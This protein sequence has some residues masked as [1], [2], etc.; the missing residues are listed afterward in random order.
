MLRLVPFPSALRPA[1]ISSGI[2]LTLVVGAVGCS[3][4]DDDGAATTTSVDDTGGSASST[5]SSTTSV[6]D[7]TSSTG[8][9]TTATS[10]DPTAALTAVVYWARPYGGPERIDLPAYTDVDGVEHPYV[11]YGSVSNAGPGDASAP[12]V[13]ATWRGADGEVVATANGRVVDPFGGDLGALG[14]GASADFIV[15][16]DDA[17]V[18]PLLDSIAPELEGVS[19]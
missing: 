15:V 12:V 10:G 2:V 5:T 7:T 14:A 4:D 18:G 19:S 11:L 6:P 8:A 13:R 9:P 3:T 16:V 1:L 17:T